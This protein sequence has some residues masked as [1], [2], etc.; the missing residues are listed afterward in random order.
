MSG[1][2]RKSAPKAKKS[3]AAGNRRL[4]LVTGLSGAG[5]SSSLK[6]LEDMGYEAVDN[7][8]LALL[9]ALLAEGG[10]SRPAVAVGIDIRTRDFDAQSVLREIAALRDR[11]GVDVRMLFLDCAGDVLTR[12]YTETRRSHPL[13]GDRPVSDGIIEERSLLAPLRE[14]ADLIVDT[15]NLVLGEL[16]HI[17]SGEFRL[18]SRPGMALFVVSFSFREALPREAD[19]VFDVRFLNNP[20]YLEELKPL[21]GRDPKVAGFIAGSPGF[22]PFFNKLRALLKSLLPQ[23]EREGKSYLTIAIGCTGGRHRSVFVA[24]KLASWLRDEEHHVSLHHRDLDL[25]AV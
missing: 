1:G 13:A 11:E 3:A 22:S 24:E 12:R 4:V 18:E 15:S 19:L 8:P 16:Q 5:R 10:K 6:G 9:G 2:K 20:H 7:L 17:L 21:S 23:Y 25:T 14:H